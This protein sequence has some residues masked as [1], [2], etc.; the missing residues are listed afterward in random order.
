MSDNKLKLYDFKVQHNFALILIFKACSTELTVL[1]AAKCYDSKTDRMYFG[2]ESLTDLQ[3][4]SWSFS[5]EM[6]KQS[7][8][9]ALADSI[10]DFA[11]AMF[12]LKV[13]NAEYALL[14]AIS[15]FSGK[16]VI[17]LA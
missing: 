10:F 14:A 6:Y 7:G 9:G 16:F 3:A 12:K 13:D 2:Q 4:V 8:F 11:K 5:R 17:I 15:L 1:K